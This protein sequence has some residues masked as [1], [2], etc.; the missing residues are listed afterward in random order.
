MR[1]GIMIKL[2]II[3]ISNGKSY[4]LDHVLLIILIYILDIITVP[5]I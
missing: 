1:F 5:C 4:N 2:E 3:W